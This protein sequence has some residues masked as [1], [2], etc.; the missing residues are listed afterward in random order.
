[1]VNHKEQMQRE[2]K[3]EVSEP[4][5]F[6]QIKWAVMRGLAYQQRGANRV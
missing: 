5:W 1:M 4:G 6:G 3:M 2:S